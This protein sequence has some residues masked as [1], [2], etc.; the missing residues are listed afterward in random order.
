VLRMFTCCVYIF[1]QCIKLSI[2]TYYLES[3]YEYSY[4]LTN[5]SQ[6]LR[7][8]KITGL[9]TIIPRFIL[10]SFACYAL[11]WQTNPCCTLIASCCVPHIR[12]SSYIG[13]YL[14]FHLVF[15]NKHNVVIYIREGPNPVFLL[16]LGCIVCDKSLKKCTIIFT[17]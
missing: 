16:S 17:D 3:S 4:T 10:E 13:D 15:F 7:N 1:V 6:E 14:G 2:L 12:S 11:L 9:N 5:T 8:V